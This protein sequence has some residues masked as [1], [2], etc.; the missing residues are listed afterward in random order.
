MFAVP[1]SLL[2]I[3]SHIILARV[4]H[5]YTLKLFQG[6]QYRISLFKV[7][8]NNTAELK[9]HKL[10]SERKYISACKGKEMKTRE[11]FG[12]NVFL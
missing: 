10:L 9:R 7:L 2:Q 3:M 12:G 6:H 4:I 8:V 11:G 5:K 1:S